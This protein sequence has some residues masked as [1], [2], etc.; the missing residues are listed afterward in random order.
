MAQLI[1]SMLSPRTRTEVTLMVLASL[2]A[3]FGAATGDWTRMRD[4]PVQE[5]EEAVAAVTFPERKAVDLQ[6][7]LR[8]ITRQNGG[9]LSLDFFTGQPVERIRRWLETFDGVGASTSA[10]VVNFSTLRLRALA[11]DTHQHRIA[12]RLELV[13]KSASAAETERL[14]LAMAPLDWSPAML[15][16]HHRLL[17]VHGQQRCTTLNWERHCGGCPLLAMCSTGERVVVE[18]WAARSGA[19]K[20][21]G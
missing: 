4:A 18:R 2:E 17:K 1:Y 9:K 13:P 10:S 20:V 11:I 15:D 21:A 6:K 19:R 5:L 8:R 7:A 12:L 14:L 16:E 3:R